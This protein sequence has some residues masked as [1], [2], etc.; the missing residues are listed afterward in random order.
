MSRANGARASWSRFFGGGTCRSPR[1]VTEYTL[2]QTPRVPR[3]SVRADLPVRH[4][5]HVRTH[6]FWHSRG[7]EDDGLTPPRGSH[8]RGARPAPLLT[9]N[10]RKRRKGHRQDREHCTASAS[11]PPSRLGDT[12]HNSSPRP[13]DCANISTSCSSRNSSALPFSIRPLAASPAP[14]HTSLRTTTTAQT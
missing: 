9:T 5:G 4:L 12:P 14:P 2:S 10:E 11:T 3:D 13:T 8:R 7:T 6:T 1:H